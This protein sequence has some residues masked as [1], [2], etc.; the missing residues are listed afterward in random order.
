[1]FG[2]GPV[3]LFIIVGLI[4]LIFGPGQIPKF[5]KGIGTAVREFRAVRDEAHKT[6]ADLD[7]EVKQI[8]R[9]AGL[10]KDNYDL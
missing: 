8:K 9:D 3:E 7:K 1:M 6:V 10:N 4:V 2:L 5:A